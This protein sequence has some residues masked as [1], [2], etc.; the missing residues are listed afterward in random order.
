MNIKRIMFLFNQPTLNSVKWSTPAVLFF[1][2]IFSYSFIL[3]DFIFG[4]LPTKSGCL[5]FNDSPERYK[6]AY[7]VFLYLGLVFGSLSA[8]A[9]IRNVITVKGSGENQ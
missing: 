5:I 2:M 3:F 4:C 7:Y 9:L 6:D 1:M 8:T